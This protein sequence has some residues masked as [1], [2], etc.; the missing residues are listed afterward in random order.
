VINLPKQLLRYSAAKIE[1][2]QIEVLRALKK[3]DAAD[4]LFCL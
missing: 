1:A 2:K 3:G 4:V